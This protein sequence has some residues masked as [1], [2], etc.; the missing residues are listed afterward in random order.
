VEPGA[1]AAG[2][3]LGRCGTDL[4]RH[5]TYIILAPLTLIRNDDWHSNLDLFEAD[6]RTDPSNGQNATWLAQLY[7]RSARRSDAITLCDRFLGDRPGDDPMSVECATLYQ[8][9]GRQ[10]DALTA[11]R[12]AADAFHSP[13]TLT[14]LA[15]LELQQGDRAAAEA[16]Y[17]RA[18][19]RSGNAVSRHVRAGEMLL[20]LHPERAKEARREFEAALALDPE[21]SAAKN[22]LS[23]ADTIETGRSPDPG[24]SSQAP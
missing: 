1:P 12:R 8:G 19:E 22:W 21:S 23:E 2:S 20:R 14:L 16:T 24:S 5:S 15:R 3:R 10:A 13:H 4:F 9:V 17:Q 18:V 7:Q 6:Y 11:L